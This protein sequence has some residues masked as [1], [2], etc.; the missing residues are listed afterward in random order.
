LDCNIVKIKSVVPGSIADEAQIEQGDS[1]ISINNEK[2][3][4]IFDYK[5]LSTNEN[6]ILKIQKSNG[7]IWDIEIDKDEDE[8]LGI[9]FESP[10]I[11]EIHTCRNKCIFCFIDQLP[12]GLRDTL[13]LKDDDSRLSFLLGNYITLTN[14][15]YKELERIIKYRMSPINVSVHTT[16]PELRVRMLNNRFAGDVLEKMRRLVSGRITVNCQIVLCKGINDGAELDR[17]IED[18]TPLYPGIKSISVVPVGITKYRKGLFNLGPYDRES[19]NIVIS[20]VSQWQK[21]LYKRFGSRIV[22]LA[23][24]FYIMAGQELPEYE[25]YE[26]FPQLENGVGMVALLKREFNEYV[27]ELEDRPVRFNNRIVSIATGQSA[28][29]FIKE[30]TV[31]LQQKYDNIRINVYTIKNDFFGKNVTV[32]GLLTGRDIASQLAGK[33]L[34]EELLISRNMLKSGEEVFLDS[35][36]VKMLEKKLGVKVTVVENSGRDFVDKILGGGL[37]CQSL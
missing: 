20:Q 32:A 27:Y 6:I 31:I 26:D 11:D 9:E 5:F 10:M 15:D 1:I 24:E 16:N 30:L 2:I 18:L 37:N 4:D 33:D 23:D 22:F 21:L 8:D 25:E 3:K 29:S 13:Y 34:G 12:K 7:E 35:Y 14:M 17:S 36:T 28:N 19:S